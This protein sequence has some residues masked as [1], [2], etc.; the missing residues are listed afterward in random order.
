MNSLLDR[1]SQARSRRC[2]SGRL[3]PPDCMCQCGHLMLA[4]S[5]ERSREISIRIALGASRWHIIRQ[6]L[7]ESL[8]LSVIGGIFGWLI[9]RWGVRAFDLATTPYG[10][11]A[12]IDFSMD[13]RV[14][15]YLWQFRSAQACCLGSRR[16]FDSRVSMSIPIS[17]TADAGRAPASRKASIQHLGDR[18]NRSCRGIA[19]RR[20]PHHSQL[21]SRLSGIAWGEGLEYPDHAPGAPGS[22][23]SPAR[24]SGVIP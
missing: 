15:A 10:K 12:W 6:L 7:V 2:W 9:A 18:R 21:S 19:R 20:G 5:V 22:Q 4:R 17:G 11:P 3:R 14:F 23:I 1:S 16:R 8:I 24:Q 13:G